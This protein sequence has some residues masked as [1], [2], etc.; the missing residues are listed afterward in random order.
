[1]TTNHPATGAAVALMPG[2]LVGQ[3]AVVTG[4]GRGN[5]RAIAIGLARAGA[6]V[7]VADIDLATAIATADVI[8][9]E[10]G[11]ALALHW[12]I[13]D[14]AQGLAAIEAIH[15]H[16]QR[17]SIL[18]NSAGIEGNG[19]IGEPDYPQDFH[20]VLGV[21]VE[22]TMLVTQSL[23][24][25]LKA[26]RGSIVN[27]TS[28]MGTVAYQ[29]GASAYAAAKAALA[30]WTRSL[31]IELA[32]AGVRVNAIAPGFMHTAMTAGTR[33]DPGRMAYFESRTP[34]KRMGQPEELVGPVLFLASILASY[35]TGAVVPVDGGL[36]AN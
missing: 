16:G 24:A 1:M 23:M 21:N 18:V 26:T 36:V 10:G 8:T 13:T 19:L 5:G 33:A 3:V 20:R 6:R 17:V 34:M 22:G 14:A 31:A 9:R 35:V 11:S 27:I 32:P 4:A 2:L 7:C 29:P 12:N 30:Q 28:M 25:D 15:R